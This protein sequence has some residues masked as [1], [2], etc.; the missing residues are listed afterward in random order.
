MPQDFVYNDAGD[1]LISNGDWTVDESTLCHQKLLLLLNKGDL[2]E[3]PTA[4]VGIQRYLKDDDPLA[5]QSE[6]K[7]ECEADGMKVTEVKLQS[8]GK[9]NLNAKYDY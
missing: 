8:D 4:C 6:I 5:L 3:H 9:L 2:K 7:R 1:T